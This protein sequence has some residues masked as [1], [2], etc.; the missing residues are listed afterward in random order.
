MRAVYTQ[1][2]FA[3]GV[4]APTLAARL[5]LRQYYQGM[6]V[7]NN[8]VV[9]PQGGVRRR[10][11][12]RFRDTLPG[13]LARQ[14]GMTITCPNGGTA[15]NA[16]D[17]DEATLVD[18][19]TNVG[20]LNPYVVVHYDLGAAASIAF[21]DVVGLLLYDGSSPTS[22][23]FCIQYSTD[24]A[25]W[26]TL[27][28]ALET[29]DTSARNYRRGSIT[30]VSARYW[31]VARVGA[32][33][34]G[35]AKVK[36]GEFSLWINGAVSGLRL[37][38]F[39]YD[40][41][42]GYVLVATD[43]NL[44]IYANGVL[45]ANARTPYASAELAAL[46]YAQAINTA[47]TVHA[48]YAPQRLLRDT[49]GTVWS[50]GTL[51]LTSYPK[52]DFNDSSSPTPTS[53][54]QRIVLTGAAWAVGDKF[55]IDVDGALSADIIYAGD[56]SADEIAKT[57]ENIRREVQKLWTVGFSGVSVVRS[58]ALT[59]DITF[60]GESADDHDLLV[61]VPITGN[62]ANRVT[63]TN[64]TPGTPRTENAWSNTRGWP[65]RA[66]F[67]E[68]RLWVGCTTSLPT[69]IFA[70]RTSSYY[71]FDTQEGL[72][73]DPVFQIIVTDQLNSVQ[74]LYSARDLVVLTSGGEFNYPESPITPSDTPELQTRYGSAPVKPVNIDGATLFLQRT[75]K[76]LRQFVFG[77]DEQ[78]YNAPPVSVLA[79]HLLNGVVDMAAWQGSETDDSNLV[80]LVN[81]DGTVA[82]LNTLRSQ[83]INAW[84]SWSTGTV[85]APGSF[86]AVATVD[87][88]VYF[89]VQRT[90]NGVVANYLEELDE[91]YYLDSA[92][93]GTNGPASATM[94]GLS[95]LNGEECRVRANSRALANVTPSGGTASAVYAG[96]SQAVT[97]YEVGIDWTPTVT[98]MPLN[99][100]LQDGDY[101]L[102]KKR[103]VKAKLQLIASLGVLVNGRELI[104]LKTDTGTFDSAPTPVTGAVELEDSTDWTWEPLTYTIS[105]VDPMPFELSMLELQLEVS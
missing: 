102:R 9:R 33:N 42:T 49:T 48:S 5:D 40:V 92:V 46:D 44:A 57:V 71:D 67:H 64:T 1:T 104:K 101:L 17:N 25:A 77:Q 31:R 65:R 82:V 55:K 13:I 79:P 76:A 52:H 61:G 45:V 54:V 98:T 41:D 95:H 10:G 90:I 12:L 14:T 97:A 69:A 32:T 99:V 18:A 86:K 21:A 29:V 35:T 83:D 68:G 88:V 89:G 37:F 103:V 84:S 20:V 15:A 11:G 80:F 22:T 75:R 59:Y 6:K 34:L 58:A 66:T 100:S 72:D 56:S 19:T 93:Q 91:D 24:N 60:A 23:E 78:A 28:T 4:L 3:A 39:E 94:T 16:N 85:D 74:A 87:E 36:L 50:F 43:R 2:S 30:G 96:H 47:I 73:D 26:T 63:A 70:S 105:Q 8:V 7:G 81:G 51:A 62:S 53:N 38:A 27:G